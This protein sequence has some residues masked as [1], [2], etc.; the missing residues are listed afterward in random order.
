MA[1]PA[2]GLLSTI[3]KVVPGAEKLLRPDLS[4][5]WYYE[6][7]YLRTERNPFRNMRVQYVAQLLQDAS[8][9]VTGDS[10]KTFDIEANGKTREYPGKWR[11]RTKLNG[12]LSFSWARLAWVLRVHIA[13]AGHERDS[14]SSHE[15][16]ARWGD[17]AMLGKFTTT[18]ANSSGTV[19]WKRERFLNY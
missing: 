1:E 3:I 14:S 10:E 12:Q 16:V 13:E 4:G 6:I 5:Q 11:V 9:R 19:H 8:G 15:L 2:L 18:I 7:R 17:S